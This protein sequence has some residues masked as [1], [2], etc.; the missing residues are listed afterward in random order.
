MPPRRVP[1]RRRS[2]RR[3][4]SSARRRRRRTSPI[5]VVPVWKPERARRLEEA[6]LPP[7]PSSSARCA[8][9]ELHHA[10]TDLCLTPQEVAANVDRAWRTAV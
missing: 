1:S 8:E 10:A 4:S 9:G 3:R 5:L 7:R 2:K 6:R